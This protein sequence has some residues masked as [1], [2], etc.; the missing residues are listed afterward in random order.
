[1]LPTILGDPIERIEKTLRNLIHEVLSSEYGENWTEAIEIFPEKEW[2]PTL[3]GK[4]KPE[5]F[6]YGQHEKVWWQCI[7]CD[8]EW[9]A[10]IFN[11]A[12]HGHGC[13]Y[14][15][16]KR[17]SERNSLAINCSDLAKEWHDEKNGT[18]KPNDVSYGSNKKV[19][20]QCSRCDR[21]WEAY[22]YKRTKDGHG[23]PYCSGKRVSERNSLAINCSDLAKEW[24]HK[25][26]V[27]LKLEEMSCNPCRI[28]T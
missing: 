19:W 13:P 7:K 24:D 11:R 28:F 1:M 17:V 3:N 5:N 26:N 10:R 4:L 21:E 25:K 14:C 12:I 6:T 16:G 9:D 20:W 2:H 23:C 8:D 18:L 27:N 15:S 22:I